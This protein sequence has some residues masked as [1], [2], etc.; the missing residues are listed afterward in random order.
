MNTKADVRV[1]CATLGF[2]LWLSAGCAVKV[3][4]PQH[5]V[6]MD[7][8][9]GAAHVSVLTIRRFDSDIKRQLQPDFRLSFADALGIA[10]PDTAYVEAAF[11]ETLRAKLGIAPPQ[12]LV[13][14]ESAITRSNN[15]PTTQTST[16]KTEVKPGELPPNEDS[17][18]Q[19]AQSTRLPARFAS[20]MPSA[21]TDPML[22]YL[23]ATALAQ[24]V[25]MLNTYVNN[26]AIPERYEAF[27]VR[28]Q[29]S[30]L[31]RAR[32]EPYD[33]YTTLS[34][35]PIAAQSS[36]TVKLFEDKSANTPTTQPSERP[37]RILPLLVTDN[38]ESIVRSS[39]QQ[40]IRELSI[41]LN[42]MIQGFGANAAASR[43]LSDAQT[44]IGRDLNSL[45]TVARASDNSVR[46]RFGAQQLGAQE[47]GMTARTHNVTVV[48]LLS[49]DT[50]KEMKANRAKIGVVA[51]TEMID[52]VSGLVL[53]SKS[54]DQR[55][56]EAAPAVISI[57]GLTPASSRLSS[58]PSDL[59]SLIAAAQQNDFFSFDG[60]LSAEE[61][62]ELVPFRQKLWVEFVS[63][64]TQGQFAVTE[65]ELGLDRLRP[66]VLP[67]SGAGTVLPCVP[68]G[69][70]G[71][72][73]KL[74]GGSNLYPDE[75][76]ASV[77]APIKEGSNQ[78]LSGRVIGNDDDRSRLTV[79]FDGL[80][81]LDIDP[82]RNL[83]MTLSASPDIVNG[84]P[85][86]ATYRLL[87]RKAGAPVTSPPPALPPLYLDLVPQRAWISVDQ[88]GLGRIAVELTR[89][90][91][92]L[93]SIRIVG[94]QVD[95]VIAP[96]GA[97][98]RPN[99]GTF[100]YTIAG[101]GVHLIRLSELRS[102]FPVRIQTIVGGDLV[103]GN[104]VN[105]QV[106]KQE[107]A[108]AP[109]DVRPTTSASGPASRASE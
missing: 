24:E 76:R 62:R 55:V 16:A 68:D 89:K 50:V 41:A 23:A 54:Y 45:M 71:V 86:S 52:S 109:T 67:P 105:L 73:V 1:C 48:L 2:I 92:N 27:V 79:T 18:A 97:V 58:T 81:S 96:N 7:E 43:Q 17:S 93:T 85:P 37:V 64:R 22:Q 47:Y 35:L 77:I 107:G 65:L 57:C 4:I 84:Q 10:V 99:P 6:L 38:L 44:A 69:A 70:G 3:P 20:T 15:A 87:Y 106:L 51:K 26:A 100:N 32:N 63:L 95:S 34:F 74:T 83:E 25:A 104:D 102:G 46:V 82:A 14:G 53:P 75:L 78:F 13:T 56:S 30:L 11:S 72:T 29:V 59:R 28:L 98:V 103:P 101:D 36:S 91:G 61:Y 39:S 49:K 40:R 12:T 31:P 19:G 108:D 90:T 8:D 33:A 42:A 9:A 88:N 66:V 60:I 5:R 80:D 21:H 94:A